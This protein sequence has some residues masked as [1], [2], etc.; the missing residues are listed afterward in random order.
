MGLLTHVSLRRYISIWYDKLTTTHLAGATSD[1]L[2]A[3]T[4]TERDRGPRNRM[5]CTE[6]R[7]G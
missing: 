6:D 4:Q 5:A 7:Y 2:I 3:D 1:R